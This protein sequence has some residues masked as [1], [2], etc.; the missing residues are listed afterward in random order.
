MIMNIFVLG[1]VLLMAYLWMARGLW[2]AL[3][4]LVCTLVAGAVAFGVWEH[5]A[6]LLIGLSPERGFLS[7]LEGVAWGVA[8]LAPYAITLAILRAISDAVV[9]ANVQNMKALDYV[10]GVACGGIAA[11][12]SIGILVIS[13][14]YTRVGAGFLGYRPI[15]YTEQRQQGSGSLER[16]GGLWLPADRLA[17][18]LYS[19]ASST[20]LR[21]GTPLS[22]W[23]P[24][25]ELA[26]YATKLSYG[27]G[28]SRNAIPPEAFRVT[29]SWS[30]GDGSMSSRDLL[31]FT[32]G[33]PP[34]A[35]VDINGE[36]VASG[37]LMGY[38]IAFEAAARESSGQVIFGNGQV[39]LLMGNDAGETIEAFP[40]ALI[41]QADAG[42]AEVFGRWRFEGDETFIA[43]VGGGTNVEMGFEF[44][45][46]T[47]YEPRALYVKN[48]RVDV[49][50]MDAQQFASVGQRDSA[51]RSGS[52]LGGGL[53]LASLD[54]SNAVR[55]DPDADTGR[56]AP[57]RVSNILGFQ[58]QTTQKRSLELDDSNRI[59][60]GTAKY[61]PNELAGRGGITPELR[62]DRF[63]P[64][65]DTAIV[66]IDIG[67]ES[68]A[69]VLGR[70]GRSVA[71]DAP[72]Q[73]IDSAGTVY[74]AIG[75]V[76]QD[77]DIVDVRITPAT[78]LRGV[79]D[80]PT[81]SAART[82]QSLVLLFRVSLG[83]EVEYYALGDQVVLEF[84]PEMLVDQVQR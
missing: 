30:V 72:P 19:H 84:R 53:D 14:G 49:S 82:D 13:V 50:S 36:Q 21:T 71:G 81:I 27:D 16:T 80:L 83:A 62:V 32:P 23:H 41:S 24:N 70:V 7:F 2:S 4:H 59:L 60:N 20:S 47:G 61:A 69:S 77:R 42:D 73:L 64:G 3:I 48:T 40:L 34:Q 35:Y 33:E 76:Y 37:R 55:F 1:A 57:V 11:I 78:P 44:L 46:P 8:L 52:V 54:T 9:P 74:Q 29:G 68:V 79:N 45:V 56:D 10:G 18:A 31:V 6:Y 58:F 51:V 26:G 43:S 28:K 25:V 38:T 15:D 22:E 5:L 39:R 17:A 75:F 12:I 66:M 63:S 67:S 65:D